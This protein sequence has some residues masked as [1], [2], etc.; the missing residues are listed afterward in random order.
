MNDLRFFQLYPD[1]FLVAGVRYCFLHLGSAVSWKA[2]RELHNP[3][4]ASQWHHEG[5]KVRH[6]RFR[7]WS[8]VSRL[9]FRFILLVQISIPPGRTKPREAQE[10]AVSYRC[11]IHPES[12]SGFASLRD[13]LL[14][15]KSR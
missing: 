14:A 6:T 12:L 1:S 11:T 3:T 15:F 8:F 2:T 7:V 5:T 4:L 13:C 9:G 10:V